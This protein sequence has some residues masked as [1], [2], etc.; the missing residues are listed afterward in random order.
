M[1]VGCGS[2]FFRIEGPYLFINGLRAG[3]VI[4]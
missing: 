4:N 1:K 2:F 3:S